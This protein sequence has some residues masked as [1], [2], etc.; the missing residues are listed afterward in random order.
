M[1]KFLTG[2]GGG[3]E[4]SYSSKE[5]MAERLDYLGWW[6]EFLTLHL[7]NTEFLKE[8][9][10]ERTK[11]LIEFEIIKLYLN[12]MPKYFDRKWVMH[13]WRN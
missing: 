9:S 6:L 7:D 8:F 3:F 4:F 5:E 13:S 2:S 10:N 1:L 12:K 11:S